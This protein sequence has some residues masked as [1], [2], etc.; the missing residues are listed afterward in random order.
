MNGLMTIFPVLSVRLT[1]AHLKFVRG[2]VRFFSETDGSSA[3]TLSHTRL[4]T[5]VVIRPLSIKNDR[6]L[7]RKLKRNKNTSMPQDLCVY[8]LESWN[9]FSTIPL[10]SFW[11]V[12][13]TRQN[14]SKEEDRKCL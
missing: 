12:E 2:F 14:V 10:T 8:H 5:L 7:I 1:L 13:T 9:I 11:A 6:K 3:L 4:A